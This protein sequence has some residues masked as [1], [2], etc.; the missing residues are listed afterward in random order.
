[1]PKAPTATSSAKP[2]PVAAGGA[3]GGRAPKPA[4]AGTTGPKIAKPSVN[5]D[6]N[7]SSQPPAVVHLGASGR[8]YQAQ[9]QKLQDKGGQ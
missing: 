2:P 8:D 4:S 7:Q 1:M 3:Q 5:Y 9:Q 6:H